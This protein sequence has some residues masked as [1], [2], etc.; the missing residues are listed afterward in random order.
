MEIKKTIIT[1]FGF[2]VALSA[3]IIMEYLLI[4][5][6]IYERVLILEPNLNILLFEIISCFIGILFMIYLFIRASE[7]LLD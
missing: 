6:F 7:E 4:A 2:S 3:L 1:I 5:I